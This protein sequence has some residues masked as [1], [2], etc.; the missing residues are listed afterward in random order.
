M[1]SSKVE[2][3]MGEVKR[4]EDHVKSPVIAEEFKIGVCKGEPTDG[5]VLAFRGKH[6]DSDV[7]EECAAI[8]PLN[9]LQEIIQGLFSTGVEYQK[10]TGV[11]IG[12]SSVIGEE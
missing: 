4:V 3:T 7:E 2:D 10:E 5:F 1:N 9:G 11:D 12:F 6:I 8:I